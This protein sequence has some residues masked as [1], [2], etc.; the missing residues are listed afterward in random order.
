MIEEID[1]ESPRERGGELVLDDRV[2]I[3]LRRAVL[4]VD[5]DALALRLVADELVD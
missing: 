2:G 3:G 5:A 4:E 1:D